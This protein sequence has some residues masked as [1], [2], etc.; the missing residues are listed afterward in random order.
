M[1]DKDLITENR[2]TSAKK[3]ECTPLRLFEDSASALFA[4]SE[5]NVYE[6][7][8]DQC[9]CPDFAIQGYLQPCKH[10]IR[11]AME[12]NRIPTDGMQSDVETARGKYYLGR[13]REYIHDADL[14]GVIRFADDFLPL[15]NQGILPK[16]DAF[17]DSMELATLSDLPCFKIMKN[18]KA[19]VEKAWSKECDGLASVIRNRLGNEVILRLGNVEF[20]K[21]C[22]GGV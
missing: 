19:K 1:F 3:K 12:L 22:C 2:L 18:G 13:A 16:D 4:G 15:L 20:I 17:A 6:T 21:A 11:L 7:T 14:A 10:M 9:S 5:G 8:L